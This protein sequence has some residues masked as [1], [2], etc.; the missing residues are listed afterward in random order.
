MRR[1]AAAG[2]DAVHPIRAAAVVVALDPVIEQM[3]V[4]RDDQPHVMR[5]EE[6]HVQAANRDARRLDVIAA[7]RAG[8]K[9]RVME[10]DDDVT[11]A[12]AVEM[13]ELIGHPRELQPVGRDVGI[14]R[15]EEA[16]P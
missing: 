3:I 4:S 5:P 12:R 1:A 11:V 14:E 7:V 16:L 9:R 13:L 2:D 6:R 10:E 8:R 15:D